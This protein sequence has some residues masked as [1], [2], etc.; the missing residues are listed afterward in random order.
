MTRIALVCFALLS[1]CSGVG[2]DHVFTNGNGGW[3]Y[4]PVLT[5]D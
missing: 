1:A 4:D 3:T 5:E 2:V